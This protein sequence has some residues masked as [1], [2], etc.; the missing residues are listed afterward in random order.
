M[1]SNDFQRK[2]NGIDLNMMVI[3]D[4]VFNNK[5]AYNFYKNLVNEY[6]SLKDKFSNYNLVLKVNIYCLL[7]NINLNLLLED[8]QNLKK[9]V[10]NKMFTQDEINRQLKVLINNF[11]NNKKFINNKYLC[12]IGYYLIN[13]NI[14]NIS[15]NVNLFNKIKKVI[16]A[17]IKNDSVLVIGNGPSSK[18]FNFNSYQTTLTMNNFYR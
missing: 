6:E 8:N 15:I 2:I 11:Y 12:N 3:G 5:N 1:L 4:V 16:N 18:N 17:K 7:E 10:I 9:L 13:K 14:H